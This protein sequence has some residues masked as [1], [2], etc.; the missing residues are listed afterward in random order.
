MGKSTRM[1]RINSL[2]FYRNCGCAMIG[3]RGNHCVE[4]SRSAL[5]RHNV[6]HEVFGAEEMKRRYPGVSYPSNYECVLDK[7]GGMLMADKM[8]KAFQVRNTTT[9]E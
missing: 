3:P 9:N 2:I 1:K 5:V 6:P 7:T 4:G 8:L